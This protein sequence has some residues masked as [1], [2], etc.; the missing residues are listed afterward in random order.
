MYRF[1]SLSSLARL[2]RVRS[3]VQVQRESALKRPKS[4][5]PSVLLMSSTSQ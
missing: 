1:V 4:E 5:W 2:L 3:L